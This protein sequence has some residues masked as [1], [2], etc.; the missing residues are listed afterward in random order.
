[1][2]IYYLR[3]IG[4]CPALPLTLRTNYRIK[5]LPRPNL[6][7]SHQLSFYQTPFRL[8]FDSNDKKK[9]LLFTI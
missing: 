6:A 5:A 3:I 8:L 7:E 1:M 9:L 2:L 4:T